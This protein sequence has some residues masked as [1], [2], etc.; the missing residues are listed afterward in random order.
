MTLVPRDSSELP[1]LYVCHQCRRIGLEAS[2]I[3]HELATGH[4]SERVS[5][6]I[7]LGV[8]QQW[9]VEGRSLLDGDEMGQP[10]TDAEYD[11]RDGHA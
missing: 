7:A 11:E 1:P 8:R 5:D 3:G 4:K 6:E 9:A 2:G 10:H